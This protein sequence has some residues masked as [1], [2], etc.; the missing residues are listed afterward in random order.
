MNYLT[1]SNTIFRFMHGFTKVLT[2]AILLPIIVFLT[3]NTVIHG[4]ICITLLGV[5]IYIRPSAK[6]FNLFA[7]A[8][9]LSLMIGIS[10]FF[11][12][13]GGQTYFEK[14]FGL[15][16]FSVQSQNLSY[17]AMSSLRM[18]NWAASFLILLFTTGVKDLIAGLRIFRIP[19][20]F[21]LTFSI[22]FRYWSL[23]IEDTK[24]VIDAQYCRG[25]D[26]RKGN[27]LS[28]LIHFSGVFA[29]TFFVFLKR[30]R[31]MSYALTLK[32]IGRKNKRTC[33]YNPALT[34]LDY[35]VI[36]VFVVLFMVSLAMIAI[37]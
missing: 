36:A 9:V 28:R 33:Y 10:Y 34:K 1:S 2:F 5:I 4:M 35:W 32:G 17:A 14:D 37:F 20:Q 27:P 29:P 16:R 13:M 3:K 7:G 6:M 24:T 30:F 8:I 19:E 25:V 23:M 26:F 21:L 22:L 12:D 11:I 31:T 18:L 15:F